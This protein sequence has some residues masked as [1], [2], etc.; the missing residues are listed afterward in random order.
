[1]IEL[2]RSGATAGEIALG[3][4]YSVADRIMEMDRLEGPVMIPGGVCEYFPGRGEGAGRALRLPGG[5]HPRAHHGRRAGRRP[6]RS[7]R[8]PRRIEAWP[9]L[10]AAAEARLASGARLKEV[11]GAHF[12]SVDRAAR[13]RSAPVAWCTSVGPAELLRALGSRST[14]P[15]TT[16][17]CWAPRRMANETY[18]GRQRAGLLARHL[19]L[20]HQ[21]HRRL[22]PGQ[23]AAAPRP[24]A[25]PSPRPDVLRLQ[26]QPVP[27][28][29]GLV[30]V[31]RREWNVPCWASSTPRTSAR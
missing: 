9:A 4:M 18:P 8:R 29:A 20:P 27:R 21:R 30:R 13:E 24:T 5:D 12:A 26:H 11:M 23:D 2:L 15:R 10:P 22:P 16:A 3:A 28:R 14:S 17:P 7:R 6:V 19:L 25:S 31:L 1:M